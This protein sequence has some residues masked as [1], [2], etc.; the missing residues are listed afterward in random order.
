MEAYCQKMSK[1]TGL[2]IE[3]VRQLM[4]QSQQAANYDVVSQN[5][6]AAS[7]EDTSGWR[8][9]DRGMTDLDYA[10]AVATQHEMEQ[11]EREQAE[12]LA[13]D[14]ALA[15][16]LNDLELAAEETQKRDSQIH[17]DRAL[18]E[19]LN[20][21]EQEC[22]ACYESLLVSEMYTLDCPMSHRFCHDCIRRHADS[23]LQSRR[24]P[25]CPMCPGSEPYELSQEEVWQLFGRGPQLDALLDAKLRDALAA[26][27]DVVACPTPNC[28][29]YLV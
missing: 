22:P 24:A 19:E 27:D 14:L 12:L 6:A 5:G 28:K 3:E 21:P 25:C 13:K 2:P 7:F 17:I 29:E 9:P 15:Q 4:Q 23:C 26:A 11:S 1:E 16:Q 8:M 20:V 18:A 10:L